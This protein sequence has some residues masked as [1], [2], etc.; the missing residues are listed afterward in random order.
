MVKYTL[1]KSVILPYF[2][3]NI[4]LALQEQARFHQPAE[5][6]GLTMH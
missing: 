6:V 2:K 1:L 5:L 3:L 4:V